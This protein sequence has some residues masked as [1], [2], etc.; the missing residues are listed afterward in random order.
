MT[1]PGRSRVA[2]TAAL[3]A[4]GGLAVHQLRYLLVFG[5]GSGAELHQEGHDYLAQALPILVG[6]AVA[7]I[8]AR[9]LV[10]IVAPV[11]GGGFGAGSAR[12]R[13]DSAGYVLCSPPAWL[14]R[15]LMYATALAS[16]FWAQELAEGAM[17]AGHPGGFGAVL[18]GGAWVALPLALTLGLAAAIVERLLDG[19]ERAIALALGAA[20]TQPAA[21]APPP[22]LVSLARVPLAARALAFGFARRPP[23]PV[24]IT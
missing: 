7:A 19:A 13:R 3:L 21:A 20:P 6:L 24:A 1:S 23:P 4:L 10:G 14:R 8:V 15:G 9:F 2:R 5:S 16:V 18:G 11:P 22:G 12:Y 17:A